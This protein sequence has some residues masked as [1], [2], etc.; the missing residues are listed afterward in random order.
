MVFVK[1]MRAA[2]AALVIILLPLGRAAALENPEFINGT[3]GVAIESL[4]DPANHDVGVAS[5]SINYNFG[6]GVVMPFAVGSRLCFEPSGDLYY[7]NARANPDGQAVPVDESWASSFVLGLLLD[8][9]VVYSLPL[10]PKFALDFGAGICFD[11]RF[12]FND[13]PDR[14]SETSQANT[15]FWSEGRFID[16]STLIRGEYVLTDK[17]AVGLE[18][19][20]LWPIYNLWTGEGFGFFDHAKYLIDLTVRYRLRPDDS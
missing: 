1:S 2:A 9:P 7:Y 17:I 11:L 13:W 20:V 15:Y 14:E 8:A 12:A 10:S 4:L 16:P 6:V 5:T 18:G 3:W 19:R